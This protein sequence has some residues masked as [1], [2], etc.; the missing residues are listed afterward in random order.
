MATNLVSLSEVKAYKGITNSTEDSELNLLIT[1]ASTLVKTY[2]GRTL[3]DYYTTE[4]TEVFGDST[5]P[6]S[7][8][9]MP[10]AEVSSVEFSLDYGRNYT[11]LVEFD[12]YVIDQEFGTLD[13]INP[14]YTG[15]KV[16]VLKVT[17]TGGYPKAPEDLK[18]AVM[19]L[20]MYY[21]KAEMAV[22]SSRA[23]GANNAQIEYVMNTTL[24]AHIRRI[25]DLYRL[26]L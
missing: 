12:D 17:Y 13:I 16:N 9:E 21:Q 6:L 26:D 5:K 20:V 8:V 19:D 15:K 25:L 23:P 22:K 24:P 7:L 11:S 10:I 4:K 3:V 1:K 14:S 2:I 18:L